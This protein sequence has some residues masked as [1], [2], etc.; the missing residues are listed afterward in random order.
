MKPVIR[1]LIADRALLADGWRNNVLLE[2]DE[3]GI[4]T[5]VR[6]DAE[7]LAL[8]PRAAATVLRRE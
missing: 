4:L 3:Q 6:P 7:V 2:W 1:Q 8:A 5:S